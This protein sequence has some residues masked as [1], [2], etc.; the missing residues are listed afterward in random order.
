LIGQGDGAVFPPLAAAHPKEFAADVNIVNAQL[1]PFGV[2]QAAGVDDGQRHLYHRFSDPLQNGPYFLAGK[3]CRQLLGRL[4]ADNVEDRPHSA[5]GLHIEKLDSGQV[6]GDGAPGS[7]AHVDQM[8]EEPAD[9][10]FGQLVGGAH[11]E[12]RQV[13]HGIQVT[14]LRLGGI[15]RQLQVFHHPSA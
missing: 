7:L 10:L 13:T 9:V 12:L 1:H 5:Q 4:G 6:N 14:L 11:V 8:E 15:A 2:T 3:H